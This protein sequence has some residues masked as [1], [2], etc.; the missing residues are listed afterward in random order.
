ML[1]YLL[2]CTFRGI[3]ET[4]HNRVHHLPN[5]FKTE[6]VG[7]DLHQH[8][9]AYDLDLRANVPLS[10]DPNILH[11]IKFYYTVINVDTRSRLSSGEK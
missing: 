9:P 8:K 5:I 10:F 11:Y 3:F 2:L 1:S 6:Y 7:Y 4:Q